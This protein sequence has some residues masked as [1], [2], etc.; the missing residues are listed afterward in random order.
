MPYKAATLRLHADLPK[1]HGSLL[2][3]IRTEKIGL[4][5]FLHQRRVP[6]LRFTG[7]PLWVAVGNC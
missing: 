5:A 4:A 2:T 1:P 3:Q 7:M 6:R